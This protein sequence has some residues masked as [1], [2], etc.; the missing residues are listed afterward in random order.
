MNSKSLQEFLWTQNVWYF[1]RLSA[2]SAHLTAQYRTY[3]LH[4]SHGVSQVAQWWGCKVTSEEG[5]H[6]WPPLEVESQAPLD[7]CLAGVF[8]CLNKGEICQPTGSTGS[9][10]SINGA[11]RAPAYITGQSYLVLREGLSLKK[12][13]IYFSNFTLFEENKQRYIICSFLV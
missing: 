12:K 6:Q 7:T 1:E 13:E 3:R 2:L 9:T 11:E 10:G 5:H 4:S 8:C